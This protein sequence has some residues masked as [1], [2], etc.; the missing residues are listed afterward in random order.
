M[1]SRR[2]RI[3]P[4]R[5]RTA[6]RCNGAVA[7]WSEQGTHNPSVEG[8]IPSGPTCRAHLHPRAPGAAAACRRSNGAGSSAGASRW[9][10]FS[11]STTRRG[12]SASRS[13]GRRSTPRSETG[14]S[15][16]STSARRPSSVS[17][18][19]PSSTSAW[20]CRTPPTRRPT[21]PISRRSGTRS[22]SASRTGTSTECCGLRPA[23]SIATS[24]PPV[25]VRSS[26]TCCFVTGCAATPPTRALRVD[27]AGTRAARVGVDGR[28]A[29]AKSDVVEEILAR[30]TRAP[31]GVRSRTCATIYR[32]LLGTGTHRYVLSSGR[33][34]R[35][36]CRMAFSLD[37]LVLLRRAHRAA[38]PAVRRHR[39]VA[40]KS[41]LAPAQAHPLAPVLRPCK[42][43]LRNNNV[44]GAA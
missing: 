21:C 25:R 12:R 5:P 44:R 8:S 17:Q 2:P 32:A 11:G 33:R 13:N 43:G 35:A 6:R 30:S 37:G 27:E 1:S 40:P 20:R 39:G 16:S 36:S 34:D 9:P 4:E 18:P 24:S 22:G 7:Q 26:G 3:G 38:V 19:S 42:H 29:T 31:M 10:S 28:Y 23:T 14:R 41:L 15:W